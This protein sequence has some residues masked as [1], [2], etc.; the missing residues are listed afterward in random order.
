[1]GHLELPQIS[2]HG[3]TLHGPSGIYVYQLSLIR[4]FYLKTFHLGSCMLRQ[5]KSLG[6]HRVRMERVN[7]EDNTLRSFINLLLKWLHWKQR[8][9]FLFLSGPVAGIWEFG[10]EFGISSCHARSLNQQIKYG[11]FMIFAG[12]VVLI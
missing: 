4:M 9:T 7:Q 2:L 12:H 1:M 11:S 8:Q 3:V 6:L 10:A 5:G